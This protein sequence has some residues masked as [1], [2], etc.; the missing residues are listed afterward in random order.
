MVV[1]DK[2]GETNNTTP[3]VTRQWILHQYPQR[4]HPISG[5]FKLIERPIYP[6][7]PPDK[8]ANKILLKILWFSNDPAQRTWI[9]DTSPDRLYTYPVREGDV[10]SAT[11]IGE[12]IESSHPEHR[13]GDLVR[14][15]FGWSEYV[16]VDTDSPRDWQL[17]KIPPKTD[18]ADFMAMGGT[19][20]AAYFGLLSVGAA[21][22][23]SDKTI[24][25]SA[26]AA[27]IGS[28]VVQIA[29]NVL[30]IKRVVG[31]AGS[32]E[33][34]NVVREECGADIALNYKSPNFRHEFEEATPEYVDIYFDNTGGEALE[35]SLR[36]IA[37][38]GRVVACG[39]IFR[40]DSCGEEM[41]L[42]AK[43]WTNI[44]LMKARVEGF[45]V[46]EFEDRFPEA[47]EQMFQWVRQGKVRP[48]KTV[49][50]AKFEEL[51]EGM[52]KLLKGEHVGKL[53]TEITTE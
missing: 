53:V 16:L 33:Q 39:A 44:I 43:A 14:G 6:S 34:C 12:V 5:A 23:S 48:L 18:P 1:F 37:R 8:S 13:K 31:I 21:S 27:A 2:P 10:M 22:S 38:N 36:R 28:I 3:T 35:L 11:A 52:V 45:V 9:S 47:R 40:Y 32:E 30:G 20:L 41:V 49:W 26:A 50:R 15:A 24:V 51:P 29:K 4:T 17:V 19:A 42:S 7:T 46:T 25:V